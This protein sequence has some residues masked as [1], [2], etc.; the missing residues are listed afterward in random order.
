MLC[1]FCVAV[2]RCQ[3]HAATEPPDRRFIILGG[4]EAA[5]IQVR[6]RAIRVTRMKYQRNAHRLPSPTGEFGAM[7]GG[8]GRH[9]LTGDMREIDA[10]ALEEMSVFDQHGGTTAPGIT[11]E[12]LAVKSFQRRDDAL[13]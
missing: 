9:G 10:A 11:P 13:L 4:N 12:G 6:G 5:H 1:V 7:R 3:I 8:R 2:I